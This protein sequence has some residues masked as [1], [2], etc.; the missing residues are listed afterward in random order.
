MKKSIFL[1]TIA[2]FL[3]LACGSKDELQYQ[4]KNNTYLQNP[5]IV[6]A[7]N[8][9]AA[10]IQQNFPNVGRAFVY[11]TKAGKAV[12]L[13]LR[14]QITQNEFSSIG[15]RIAEHIKS[16]NSGRV[17]VSELGINS[18]VLRAQTF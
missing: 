18:A 9:A 3:F 5:N 17:L 14:R 7:N 1:L 12:E 11:D 13:V 16:G 6:R 10:W 4:V 2:G 8:E 15:N